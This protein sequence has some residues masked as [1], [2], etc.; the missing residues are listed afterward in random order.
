MEKINSRG[1]FDIK[2]KY[3]YDGRSLTCAMVNL[4]FSKLYKDSSF[5]R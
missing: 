3:F 4:E 2:L 5:P 1:V